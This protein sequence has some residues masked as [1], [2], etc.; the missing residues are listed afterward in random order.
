MI[1]ANYGEE[2]LG[3]IAG[4]GWRSGNATG[5]VVGLGLGLYGL[6]LLPMITALNLIAIIVVIIIILVKFSRIKVPKKQLK[7]PIK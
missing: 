2:I 1:N 4:E 7:K 3:T 5:M 6:Y